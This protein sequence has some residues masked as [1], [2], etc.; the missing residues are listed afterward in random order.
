MV[1]SLFFNVGNFLASLETKNKIEILA[2]IQDTE[3]SKA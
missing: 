3:T 1:E 2:K